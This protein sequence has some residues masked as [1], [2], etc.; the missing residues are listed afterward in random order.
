MILPKSWRINGSFK[1]YPISSL[2]FFRK[3][4]Q[5]LQK[6]HV[7]AEEKRA[8]REY[9]LIENIERKTAL[10]DVQQNKL[11][12]LQTKLNEIV[13]A[14]DSLVLQEVETFCQ[15]RADETT[16]LSSL[17]QLIVDKERAREEN[18]DLE[19]LNSKWK[20]TTE[21][22]LTQEKVFATL[23][24]ELQLLISQY[25]QSENI[26]DEKKLELEAKKEELKKNLVSKQSQLEEMYDE[27]TRT[28]RKYQQDY[29]NRFEIMCWERE[30]IDQKYVDRKKLI[31]SDQK[32]HEIEAQ[33][34]QTKLDEVKTIHFNGMA[35]ENEKLAAER[36]KVDQ[37]KKEAMKK[38]IEDQR[39]FNNKVQ[40]Y[41][42]ILK[43]GQDRIN[44]KKKE[45][46][47]IR[48]ELTELMKVKNN[49]TV[50]Q[51]IDVLR[52][53]L[54][55][56]IEDIHE[57]ENNLSVVKKEEEKVIQA[58]LRELNRKKVLNQNEAE[59]SE[60]LLVE[61]EKVSREKILLL[62]EDVELQEKRVLKCQSNLEKDL[63][64]LKELGKLRDSDSAKLDTE[65]LYIAYLIEKDSS[66]LP[67]Q[68][69]ENLDFIKSSKVA[70]EK[71]NL[72]YKNNVENI[73]RDTEA[74]C[75]NM[76]NERENSQIVL[77]DLVR[78]RGITEVTLTELKEQFT[79]ERKEELEQIESLRERL[80]DF[81]EERNLSN[82]CSENEIRMD[83]QNH[84]E[85]N[86]DMNDSNISFQEILMKEKHKY[87]LFTDYF[88][89]FSS[90]E[91]SFL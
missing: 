14:K 57:L 9:E 60:K 22:I 59:L 21:R 31:E 3:H 50:K 58:M 2:V 49:D 73:Q 38:S 42:S 15:Q 82:A 87:I 62:Q 56:K 11:H 78:A 17:V 7:E 55:D 85:E 84:S 39:E 63:D 8:Q 18:F 24:S 52:L 53:N 10:I 29:K 37:R 20:Q 70:L 51:K 67:E 1:Q 72:E 35:E 91:K 23:N 6:R 48:K 68:N 76:I 75:K 12:E 26:S 34:A 77:E 65:L 28:L 40:Q 69:S 47:T 4:L 44:T 13:K 43:T 33:D 41:R 66:N 54:N 61:F 86:G 81:E 19:E 46:E 80:A 5:E 90:L 79:L 64:K 88:D 71:I 36:Y 83:T 32:L 27:K 16:K 89:Q 74:S 45:T 25:E 30:M